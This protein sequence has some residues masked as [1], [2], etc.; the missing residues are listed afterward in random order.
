MRNIESIIR[1]YKDSDSNK[2]IDMFLQNRSNR[3][4]FDSMENSESQAKP[5][6][7]LYREKKGIENLSAFKRFINLVFPKLCRDV[8]F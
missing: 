6:V 5:G 7:K 8:E 1:E 4:L 3:A 2:R